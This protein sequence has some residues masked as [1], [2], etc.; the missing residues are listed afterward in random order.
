MT[1]ITWRRYRVRIISLSLYVV[2]LIVF[3]VLTQHAFQ[4]AAVICG[5]LHIDIN[6]GRHCNAASLAES[7]GSLVETSI[8]LLPFFIGLVLGTPL[9]AS[10]FEHKTN[11]LAWSQGITRTRWLVRTWLTLAIP[12]VVVMSFFA[13]IVQW[14]ATHIV[15]SISSGGG[16]IQPAQMLIS[17]VAPIAL[18]LM[19]LTLGVFIGITVRRFFSPY[20]MS[21]VTVLVVMGVMQFVLPSL[22]PKVVVPTY[23]YGVTN[24]PVG[25]RSQ[26]WPVGSGLRRVPGFHVGTHARTV[27]ATF[28]YCKGIPACMRAH[29]L[30][31]VTYYQPESHYWTLQW[32]EAGLYVAAT[33]VLLSLSIWSIRRWSA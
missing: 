10:E 7:R 13:L 17:G 6:Q 33:G 25:L 31:L 26:L 20:A 5:R 23:P 27:S 30:Q 4:N 28:N 24:V 11:R 29:G 15:T 19:L 22:A 8:A 16:L 18:A 32:R 3:M 1:W 2:A 21:V 9:V 14:W 12:T